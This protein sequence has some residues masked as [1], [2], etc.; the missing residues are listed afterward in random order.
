MSSQPSLQY[1]RRM[2]AYDD[3]AN[4][5]VLESLR[6]AGARGTSDAGRPPVPAERAPRAGDAPQD[7]LTSAVRLAAH[8]AGAELLWLARIRGEAPRPGWPRSSLDE[9]A[10]HFEDA[11]RE[12]HAI[13][14]R[15]TDRDLER[16]VDY[17]NS[18][19]EPWQ[20]TVGDIAAHVAFHGAHHRGQIAALVRGAGFAPAYTD[21]IHCVR[22]GF[23]D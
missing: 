11:A 13:L 4:R 18:E 5:E 12:W 15:A 3:W 16:L 6:K 21:Y 1:T 8:I 2:L 9:C 14:E 7:A 17:K 23:V 22:Q 10:G 19:G 20:S